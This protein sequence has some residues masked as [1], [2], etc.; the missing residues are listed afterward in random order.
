M[1]H[2]TRSSNASAPCRLEWR[3]S[4]WLLAALIV[5]T[6]L[7]AC[8]LLASALPRSV[9]WP[10]ALVAI[11]VGTR[12][13]RRESRRTACPIVVAADGRATVDGAQ[14]QGFAV[15]WR[16][17]LAFAH[18]R[19][20]NGLSRRCSFWPDTL[21]GPRRRELRLAAAPRPGAPG[22]GGMAH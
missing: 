8:S 18:W 21:P 10:S 6:V 17:P 19:D 1:P 16:G 20:A 5:L 12:Q 2:S 9:A 3:P 11:M 22:A 13:L 4:R 7:A 15:D 14:V